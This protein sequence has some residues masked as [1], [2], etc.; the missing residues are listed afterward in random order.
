LGR[1]FS[2]SLFSDAPGLPDLSDAA[3][4]HSGGFVTAFTDNIKKGSK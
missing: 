4:P 3:A 1:F 2:A